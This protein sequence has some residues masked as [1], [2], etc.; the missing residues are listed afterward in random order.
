VRGTGSTRF[1]LELFSD[2][3]ASDS[4]AG[5]IDVGTRRYGWRMTNEACP[6]CGTSIPEPS[7]F[8]GAEDGGIR[9][10]NRYCPDCNRPLVWF[11]DG[12]LAGAWRVD[13]GIAHL[14]RVGPGL[15]RPAA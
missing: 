7:G 8:H 6:A 3:P 5:G 15:L 10:A 14:G 1:A 11:S 4:G 12:A 9:H 13:N 2:R